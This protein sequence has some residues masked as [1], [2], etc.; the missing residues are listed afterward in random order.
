MWL[1]KKTKATQRGFGCSMRTA[2]RPGAPERA[3]TGAALG[4]SAGFTEIV[5]L[6]GNQMWFFDGTRIL[7]RSHIT[8]SVDSIEGQTLWESRAIETGTEILD[9]ETA[10]RLARVYGGTNA[11]V[12]E[13]G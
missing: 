9:T 5:L 4:C 8:Q 10:K 1:L 12:M 7:D 6:E 13:D 3:A 2:N 11:G